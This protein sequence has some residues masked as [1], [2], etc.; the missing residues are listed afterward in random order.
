MLYLAFMIHLE[1]DKIVHTKTMHLGISTSNYR[2]L[3]A[4]QKMYDKKQLAFLFAK[5]IEKGIS[6][7]VKILER[8]HQFVVLADI[9]LANDFQGQ[10]YFLDCRTASN[11]RLKD[12]KF[13]QPFAWEAQDEIRF[14][15][16][17]D[18]IRHDRSL[19][20]VVMKEAK[21]SIL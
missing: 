8:Y 4:L 17:C 18:E 1:V 14:K 6:G 13:F 11:P 16:I 9:V 3:E 21:V 20:I 2:L 12:F 19:S 5:A 15:G 10:I 7:G